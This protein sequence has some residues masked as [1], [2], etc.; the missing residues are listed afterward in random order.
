MSFSVANY[1]WARWN[2]GSE[3]E[4]LDW[5]YAL[6]K[7]LNPSRVLEVGFGPGGSALVLFLACPQAH[8]ISMDILDR[9]EHVGKFREILGFTPDMTIL[10]GDSSHL[11][12]KIKEEFD[13]AYID[14]D[15]THN[16]VL[17]DATNA[18]KLLKID[19]ILVFDDLCIEGVHS[20]VDAWKR[21]HPHFGQTYPDIP[22]KNPHTSWYFKKVA[23]GH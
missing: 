4:Y 23:H 15:H 22:L 21:A 16:R 13:L 9:R 6:V 17:E 14:G 20:G 8:L 10:Q 2:L 12:P 3:P 1:D 11:V 19:G 5:Y 18:S 7:E